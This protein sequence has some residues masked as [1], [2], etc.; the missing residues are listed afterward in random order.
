MSRRSL[1]TLLPGFETRADAR[2]R[3]DVLVKHLL[4]GD[5]HQRRAGHALRRC[6]ATAPC[7]QP[8]CPR[9]VRQVRRSF[10]QA[11]LDCIDHVRR[12][13]QLKNTPITAFSAVLTEE[14]YAAGDLAD[15]DLHRINER[16]QRRHLR[17]G[18][19]LV[20]AG[21]DL[22]FNTRS[23][24]LEQPYW[25]FQVYG[26][27]VGLDCDGT[28]VALAY[29]YP[30]TPNTSRPLR[31]RKC[32]D[33]AKALSYIIKPYFSERVNYRD[34]TG[35]MN[36]HTVRLKPDQIR[37]LAPWLFQYPLTERYLLTGAR[38]YSDRIEVHESTLRRLTRLASKKDRR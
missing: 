11:A 27:V 18:F 31:V 16:L 24:G 21:V 25:Q 22:S 15:A 29:L 17:C 37:E 30:K 19:S 34:T 9:C 10:V 1:R 23:D 13:C 35:R 8:I 2:N 12:S 6:R 5:Y 4:G 26:V 14:Q 3:R 38:R 7:E 20:F 32:D 33:L 36:I 28:K